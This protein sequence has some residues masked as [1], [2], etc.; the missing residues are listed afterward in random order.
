MLITVRMAAVRRVGAALALSV[1]LAGVGVAPVGADPLNYSA[2]LTTQFADVGGTDLALGL[3][4]SSPTGYFVDGYV[5]RSDTRSTSEP[6]DPRFW[7]AT[8]GKRFGAWSVSVGYRDF[9]DGL[10]VAT[11]DVAAEL[12]WLT[13]RTILSLSVS[14]GAAD[15]TYEIVTVNRTLARTV[16]TDRLAVGLNG[17]VDVSERLTLSAGMK[18]YEYDQPEAPLASLPRLQALLRSN[19]FTAQQGLIDLSWNAGASWRF[20][21]LSVS[22]DFGRSRSR[23]DGI[24]SD[25]L[26]IVLDVPISIRWSLSLGAGRYTTPDFEPTNYASVGIRLRGP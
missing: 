14:Q 7:S 21:R 13:N 9:E 2:S 5:A 22:A 10:Q 18:R 25:D 6:L 20:N 26:S 11:Q 15:E 19:V 12:G 3:G 23:D 17:A 8:V 4:V 24:E 1:T 16:A